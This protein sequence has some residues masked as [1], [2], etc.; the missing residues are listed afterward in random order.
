ME[1]KIAIIQPY[2]FPYL[3]YFQLINAVDEFILYDDVNFIKKGWV[4]RNKILV[5]EKGKIIT[6]PCKNIS[7]NKLIKDVYL[8]KDSKT[9]L[10]L[11]ETIKHAY[12]KAP[13]FSDVFH[14]FNKALESNCKT[15]SELSILSIKEVLNYLDLDVNLK[16]SSKAYTG[17][18][19][20]SKEDRLINI[21]K[22]EKC[23]VYINAIGGKAIYS[24][25]MFSKDEIVLKFL[26]PELPEYNQFSNSEFI[27]GLSIIDV[28]MFNSPDEIR[29]MLTKYTLV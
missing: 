17:L 11:K 24:K 1:H 20:F 14:L 5:Q 7:Q 2:V 28:M 6:F 12:T 16:I 27:K 13:Y 19:V 3:G 22:I 15:I 25:E 21:C 18:E 8:H 26:K 9:Y 10:N 23:N 29:D 4:N